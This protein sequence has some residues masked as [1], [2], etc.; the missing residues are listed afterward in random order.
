M[1]IV[2]ENFGIRVTLDFVETK[3]L[4]DIWQPKSI[5]K[6]FTVNKKFQKTHKKQSKKTLWYT[7]NKY[8]LN[9]DLNLI[10]HT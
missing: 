4:Q 6:P 8:G 7:Y 5:P 3:L 1:I 9:A 2:V 10:L